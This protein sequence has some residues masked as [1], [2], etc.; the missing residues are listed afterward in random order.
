MISTCAASVKQ[1][2][3]RSNCNLYTQ[4]YPGAECAGGN[5]SRRET[6]VGRDYGSSAILVQGVP[7]EIPVS[8]GPQYWRLTWCENRKTYV[9]SALARL[10]VQSATLLKRQVRLWAA[11]VLDAKCAKIC[12][13]RCDAKATARWDTLS[14]T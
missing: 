9:N 10:G 3:L 13:L 1:Q 11:I 4:A 5:P 2:P 14:V 7:E 12:R 8:V 6:L